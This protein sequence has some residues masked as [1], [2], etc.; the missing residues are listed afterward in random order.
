VAAILALNRG[1]TVF[2]VEAARIPGGGFAAGLAW[3]P[4]GERSGKRVIS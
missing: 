1:A 4:A 3:L 2:V